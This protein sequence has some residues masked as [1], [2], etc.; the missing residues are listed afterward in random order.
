MPPNSKFI[1]LTYVY[2]YIIYTHIYISIIYHCLSICVLCCAQMLTCVQPLVI[3]W[4]VALQALL[5]LG[6]FW[7]EYWSGLPFLS[8]GDLPNPGVKP[9]SPGLQADSLLSEPKTTAQLS[10]YYFY[11]RQKAFYPTQYWQSN[12]CLLP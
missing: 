3:P 2:I 7:K 6:F 1:Y 4:T 8:P 9:G 5:S 12:E 11:E 10:R